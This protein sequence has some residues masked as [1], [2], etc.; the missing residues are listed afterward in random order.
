M[1]PR[2]VPTYTKARW[3]R[4]PPLIA[5]CVIA[6]APHATLAQSSLPDP[7]LTPGAINP[8]ITQSDI[9]STICVRG[10]T[11]TVRPPRQYTDRLKAEQ[12]RE[13]GYP[14]I[15]EAI[16]RRTTSFRSTWAERRTTRGT[17]GPS[18]A[19]PATAGQRQE[20]RAGGR[21][22][23]SSLCRRSAARCRAAGNRAQLA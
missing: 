23:A 16:T 7:A 3:R 4:F 21:A 8:A 17:C 10:W 12:I 19:T 22:G 6:I 9:Q 11:R 13:Y 2:S 20:G 15:A 1:P 14:I 5:A 18:R